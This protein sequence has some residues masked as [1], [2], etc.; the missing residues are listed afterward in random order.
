MQTQCPNALFPQTAGSI[1]GLNSGGDGGGD[2][3]HTGDHTME[4]VGYMLVCVILILYLTIGSYMELKMFKWGH[5]TGV[6]IFIGIII[7]LIYHFIH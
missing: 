5:E 3:E 6:I 7:G 2:D 1:L 4:F